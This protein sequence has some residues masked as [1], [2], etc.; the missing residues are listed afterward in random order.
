MN[1]LLTKK[2]YRV[3]VKTTK[4]TRRKLD[5]INNTRRKL[6]HTTLASSVGDVYSENK[7]IN[8]F[9]RVPITRLWNLKG[10]NYDLLKNKLLEI[11]NWPIEEDNNVI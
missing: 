8:N 5:H 9:S 6:D 3:F 7:T 4:Y 2:V 11:G 1:S 10:E